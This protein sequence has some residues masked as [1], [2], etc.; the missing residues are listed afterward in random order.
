MATRADIGRS[1][2]PGLSER[3]EP[4]TVQLEL[5][6]DPRKLRRSLALLA[7][8]LR[9]LEDEPARR[10]R[11]LV[12][13]IVARS[14]EA[15]PRR[16]GSICLEI[17]ATASHVRLEASGSALMMPSASGESDRKPQALFPYWALDGLADRWALDRRAQLPAIWFEIRRG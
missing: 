15:R 8:A 7:E 16:R 14:A 1:E 13:E 17:S 2:P 3:R 12:T 5:D 9:D 11:L 6:P 10:V 4:A